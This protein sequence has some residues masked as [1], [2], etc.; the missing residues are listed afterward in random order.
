VTLEES[1]K[2]HL[3]P[4]RL[5]VPAIISCVAALRPAAAAA[6][7]E[8]LLFLLLFLPLRL[9]LL[10]WLLLLLRRR[11]RPIQALA[12]DQTAILNELLAKAND[13]R[14]AYLFVG[15]W[16]AKHSKTSP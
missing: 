4:K 9:L 14:K 2:K 3:S 11:W 1:A 8:V 5:T 13:R 15:E 7:A 16:G 12:R 10:P 6:A